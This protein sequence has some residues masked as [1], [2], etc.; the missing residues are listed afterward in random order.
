[1]STFSAVCKYYGIANVDEHLFEGVQ[2]P[3]D[4]FY[5]IK[6]ATFFHCFIILTREI[7]E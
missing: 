4:W 7:L 5:T 1:M 2:F 6:E 3:L